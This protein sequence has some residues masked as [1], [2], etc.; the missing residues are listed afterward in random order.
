MDDERK[1]DMN[2]NKIIND[3]IDEATNGIVSLINEHPEIILIAG[4]VVF[5]VGYNYGRNKA[6]TDVIR[7]AATSE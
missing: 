5:Y 6:M 3:R 4:A 7:L 2:A 1:D